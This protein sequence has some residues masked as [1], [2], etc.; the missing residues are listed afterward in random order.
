MAY[1]ALISLRQ[2]L[3]RI[4]NSSK[5]SIVPPCPEIKFA[6]EEATSAVPL[7]YRKDATGAEY[8]NLNRR[9]GEEACKL[10]DVLESHISTAFLS[11][12][13]SLGD[14]QT[15]SLKLIPID[16]QEVVQ[17]IHS[18]TESVK[19]IKEEY[20]TKDG[21]QQ[22]K[23]LDCPDL[24]DDDDVGSSTTDFGGKNSKLFGL[25]N[26]FD[27]IQHLLMDDQHFECRAWV[28]IGPRYQLKKL[29]RGILAQVDP[30][31][32]ERDTE[33]EDHLRAL[34]YQGLYER[35]YLIVFDDI[36]DRKVWDELLRS[37]PWDVNGSRILMT[38]RLEGLA[39]Y[40]SGS[41]DY[42]HR[43]QFLNNDESWH[44][45]C[46]KVFTEEF[47]P[48]ELKKV[49]KK[50]VQNCEGLPLAI[51]AVPELRRASS[52]NHRGWEPPIQIR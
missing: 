37:C 8:V 26:Q 32:L 4:L 44:M 40:A 20:N 43:M 7:L 49:A 22:S 33:S 51:I 39:Y 36:W 2:A 50:I 35:K 19:K 24:E 52:R 13:E 16:F 25:T 12:S 46:E 30:E 28:T 34:L 23:L 45:F 10:E 48:S 41:Y 47:W 5:I 29:M 42:V 3:E 18:F 27:Q 15:S 1:A 17:E 38:T 9:I 21:E 6:Y 11:L 14:Y 31:Y